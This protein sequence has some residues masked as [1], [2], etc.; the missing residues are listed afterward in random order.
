MPL[1]TKDVPHSR[2]AELKPPLK[3]FLSWDR[4]TLMSD[5]YSDEIN[6]GAELDICVGH[7]KFVDSEADY[8]FLLQGCNNP[9]EA[10]SGRFPP[11]VIRSE[12]RRES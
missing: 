2:D 1:T 5:N 9:A 8:T 10:P 7:S 6:R 11:V 4:E 3:I 12:I